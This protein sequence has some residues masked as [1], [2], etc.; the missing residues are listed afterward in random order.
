MGIRRPVGDRRGVT[1]V[2]G[3]VLMVALTIVLAGT[4]LAFTLA[5][6]EDPSAS[7]AP[8]TVFEFD[9][10]SS[11]GGSD[12]VTILHRSGDAIEF[13]RLSVDLDGA[14][15]DGGSDDPDG[16]YD[17][18]GDSG[19]TGELTAGESV[20]LTDPLPPPVTTTLCSSG[21]LELSG[22]SVRLIWAGGEETTVVLR[23]WQV[24][25]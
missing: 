11:D 5:I 9:Y 14:A 1:P 8:T 18:V 23:S 21:T 12:N 19:R 25:G 10:N 22:A 17:A 24:P 20:L 15:C 3:I 16:L 13:S 6:D 2:V 7:N 4:V